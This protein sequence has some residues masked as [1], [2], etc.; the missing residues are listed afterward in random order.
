LRIDASYQHIIG[1]TLLAALLHASWNALLRGA[2][3]GLWSITLMSLVTALA[4]VPLAVL[5]PLPAA[6]SWPCL[7]IS[8]V[9]QVGYSVFLAHAY[10]H[11][12][13]GQV[14]PVLRGSVPLLVTLGGFALAGQRLSAG[15]L[16]GIALISLGIA[17]LTLGQA[18]AA[19]RPLVLALVAAL[20]VAGYVTADGIGVRLAGNPGSYTAW[21]LLLF[22]ALMPAA[23]QLLG[24]RLLPGPGRHE[25]A[26]AVAA[27]LLSLVSYAC[28]LAALALGDLG[29]VAALRETSVVFSILLA[30]IFLAE[31]LTLRRLLACLLVA[32][33]AMC[34]G[35]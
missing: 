27:G 24:H 20:F 30:R 9:L 17:S 4:A 21:V 29:P 26:K 13:L 3:D 28:M 7:A 34:I 10:R 18:R 35:F 8:A 15:A 11:G 25:S 16:L 33:G 12:E 2:R 23:Y 14:Y 5:L 22:G 1:L 32:L 6:V 19:A 31:P